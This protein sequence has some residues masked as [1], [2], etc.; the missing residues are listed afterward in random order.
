MF[1]DARQPRRGGSRPAFTLVELVM[2]VVIL[3]IMAALAAPRVSRGAKGA[4]AHALEA[5]LTNVRKAIDHY[6]AEHGRYPGYNPADGTPSGTAFIR[7]LTQFTDDVGAPRATY[8]GAWI[9]GPYLREPFP[10][11]PFNQLSTVAVV[12]TL[13]SARPSPGSTGW[14]AVL[15][16]GDFKVNSTDAE[17]SGKGGVSDP[18]KRDDMLLTP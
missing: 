18:G 17:L 7:Q 12:Q 5:T 1:Q 11:N 13:A 2:V 4:S 3:G 14:I 15:S 9:Y 10:A 8:G 6:Y 16:T